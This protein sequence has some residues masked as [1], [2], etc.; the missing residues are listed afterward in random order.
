MDNNLFELNYKQLLMRC[1]LKGELCDNRTN[2]KTY[3]LF[4][5]SFNINLKKG[6]PIVTG[7]KIF[8]SKAL[9]EFKWIYEGRTDLKYLQDNNI[10]WW[11]EFAINNKLGKI[12][13]YQLR[14]FNNSFDQIK[15]VIN[16]IKNNSRRALI[17]LW[18]PTDLKEQALPCCYTQI[19]F[20]RVNNKLN[21]SISF[22]SSDL[23]LGLPYD[24][25]FAALLLKT[26]SLQCNLQE[27]ILGINIADAHIYECHKKNVKEYYN[28][29]NYVLP[30]LKG[31]Y[32]NY[33]LENYKHNKYIKSKLVL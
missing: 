26:I 28:N 22:R 2:E 9:A 11:D 16:E 8:F 32:N 23:F 24:I 10:N 31:D 33:T 13:G 7:K 15:Y 27:H 17:S 4:N 18:N 29:V 5:Q 1:L 19:N 14:K 12:Y 30:K 3:K 25:I 6:F 21:M 20:V